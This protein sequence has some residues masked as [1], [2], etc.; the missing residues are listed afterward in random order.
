MDGRTP[1]FAVTHAERSPEWLAE[2]L[3]ERDIAVWW[4]NYY[5]VEVME[6]LGLVEGAVRIGFVHYNTG[7]E[8]DRLV[9]ALAELA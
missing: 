9:A 3:A 8:V 4:G 5:A 6:R 1:T 7:A 2:R